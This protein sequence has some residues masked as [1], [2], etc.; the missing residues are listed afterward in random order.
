MPRAR[1]V[2]LVPLVRLAHVEQLDR[3]VRE[4]PLELLERDRLEALVAAA[5]LPACEREQPDRVQRSR[6]IPGLLF[7]RRVEEERTL[8]QDERRFRRKVRPAER[9]ADRSRMVTGREHIRPPHIELRRPQLNNPSNGTTMTCPRNSSGTRMRCSITSSAGRGRRTQ[10]GGVGA[11]VCAL[12]VRALFSHECATPLLP[13]ERTFAPGIGQAS[14]QQKNEDGH[15]DGRDKWQLVVHK[16]PRKQENDFD[17]EDD[18]HQRIQVVANRK[19]DLRWT[20]RRHATL[21]RFQLD[22][23]GVA[24]RDEARQHQRD[25]GEDDRDDQEECNWTVSAEH[26]TSLPRR[27]RRC[28]SGAN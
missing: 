14:E 13:F 19:L 3:V 11:A 2:P 26:A 25:D 20:D 16:C 1:D 24:G 27:Q 17:V 21:V 5:F 10:R 8:G 6:G 12:P 28:A 15:I 23:V 22:R 7:V 9:D 18:E 4:Q